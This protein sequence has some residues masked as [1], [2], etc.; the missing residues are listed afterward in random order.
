M[1]YTFQNV[2]GP[3]PEHNTPIIGIIVVVFL[4]KKSAE[5]QI[6]HLNQG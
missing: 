2:D 5:E 4:H 1:S 6:K 3:M